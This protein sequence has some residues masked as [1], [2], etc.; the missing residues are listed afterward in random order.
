MPRRNYRAVVRDSIRRLGASQFAEPETLRAGM[1]QVVSLLKEN[2]LD[3]ENPQ[4]V[5]RA[6]ALTIAAL[7]V[8]RRGGRPRRQRAQQKEVL[9]RYL[10]LLL[11]NKNMSPLQVRK[12]LRSSL[13]VPAKTDDAI[14]KQLKAAVLEFGLTPSILKDRDEA[15]SALPSITSRHWIH[16]DFDIRQLFDITV[17]FTLLGAQ[18]IKVP[19]H[20]RKE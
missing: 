12:A 13:G 19:R 17:L 6:F 5:S 11:G 8:P 4:D 10:E 2:D 14:R 7:F 15:K 20:I 3:P 18:V 1:D 16:V 9:K